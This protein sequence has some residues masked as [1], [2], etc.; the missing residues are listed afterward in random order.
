MKQAERGFTLVE[1]AIAAALVLIFAAMA[2]PKINQAFSAWQ[3]NADARNIAAT[4]LSAKIQAASNATSYRISFT[5][6]DN[7]WQ[8]QKRNKTTQV[9]EDENPAVSLSSGVSNSG[10]HLKASASSA[11][12]GF[13]TTA[14][15][16]IRFNSRGIP[17]DDAG[18]PTGNNAIYLSNNQTWYSVT[19]SSTGRVELWRNDSGTWS[20]EN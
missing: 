3:L 18:V 9:F 1:L 14:S 13:P 2:L 19:V 11:P 15:A 16:F 6:G 12:T 5:P 20:L 8:L 17:V 10:I 7:S 4:L